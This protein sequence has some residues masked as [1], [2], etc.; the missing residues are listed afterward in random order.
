MGLN[1]KN[2]VGQITEHKQN[3]YATHEGNLVLGYNVSLE[4]YDLWFSKDANALRIRLI[5][6]IGVSVK[7]YENVS[8]FHLTP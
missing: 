6:E 7:F 3:L 8:E 4:D 2:V 1:S 5:Y